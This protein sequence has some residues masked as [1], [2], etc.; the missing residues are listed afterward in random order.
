[1]WPLRSRPPLTTLQPRRICI[2]K[3]S[4]LGD[5]VQSLPVLSAL[6]ERW[7]DAHISWVV[8]ECF[9]D[10]LV[11]HPELDE[12]IPFNGSARRSRFFI[13]LARL[14]RVLRSRDY[15]LAIDLQGLLRSGAMVQAT[16][17]RRRI[18][19]SCGREGST[20]CYTDIVPVGP[21]DIPVTERYWKVVRALGI[22]VDIPPVQLGLRP[23]HH[24]FA[25][26]AVSG[27]DGPILAIHPSAGWE[28]KRWPV[29]HFER[30]A[31][32]A[33]QRHRASILLIGGKDAMPAAAQIRK[34][35][36]GPML[37]LTGRT[38]LRE[39]AAVISQSDVVLSGDS[40][41]MHLAAAMETRV[42]SLFTCTNTIRHA[43]YGQEHRVVAT[44]VSCAASHRKV[45]PM[46]DCMREL[47]PLRVWPM[48]SA[49]L[50]SCDLPAALP[51]LRPLAPVAAIA[52]VA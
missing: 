26:Q 8:K 28:T 10:L 13:E 44:R 9:S 47:T 19:F 15:D 22:D 35:A 14:G 5:I 7:P 43:P 21:G 31:R 25:T 51:P 30:I 16:G 32:L 38:T 3:P 49:T 45:C 34:S 52:D 40:G 39:L 24:Q 17:A 46:M 4:A 12:V 36:I 20:L 37:D 42:V 23:E 48:L 11:D 50:A 29:H 2:V 6:R 33:Y 27:L 18:G 41:P 1:M